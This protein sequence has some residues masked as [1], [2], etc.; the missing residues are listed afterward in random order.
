[1]ARPRILLAD[2]HRAMLT[3]EVSLL[4]TNFEVIGIVNDGKTL[5]SEANRLQ[6]DVIVLDITMP[7]MTG[8]EAAHELRKSGSTAKLVFLT[9]HQETAFIDKCFSEG[10]SAYV[11]KSRM[12]SDLVPA[13]RQA[14]SNHP[15]ISPSMLH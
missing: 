1:L 12:V 2:D 3:R 11:I 5:V 4:Q 10:G 6:P 8:I 9:V 15:F 7:I 14:L 13:I